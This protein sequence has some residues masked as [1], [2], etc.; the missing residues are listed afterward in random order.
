MVSKK[1]N[2]EYFSKIYPL[3]RPSTNQMQRFG[4]RSYETWRTFLKKKSNSSDDSA[5]IVNFTFPHY[6]SMETISC[7]SN[8]SSLSDRNKNIN[9]VEGGVQSKY[10]KFQLHPPYAF[11]EEDFGIL[12]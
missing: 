8:Q 12:F 2:F 1:K 9:F 7:H 6:K 5:E 11:R 10:A 3:C 4:Q